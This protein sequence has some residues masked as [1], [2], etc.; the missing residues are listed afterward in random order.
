MDT[1]DY[2]VERKIAQDRFFIYFQCYVMVCAGMWSFGEKWQLVTV[3]Q[4]VVGS[5]PTAGATLPEPNAT[6]LGFFGERS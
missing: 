1:D 4:L 5:I 3:N 6:A 2:G